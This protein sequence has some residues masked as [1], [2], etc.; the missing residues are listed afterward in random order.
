MA[1][2]AAYQQLTHTFARLHRFGHLGAIAGWDQAAMMPPKGNEARAAAMAELQVL[3]HQIITDPRI[4]EQLQAAEQENL[5]E[6]EC[7]NLREMRREW[8]QANLLPAN[9]VEA[10]ALAGARCEHAWRQQRPAND[11]P[12]FAANLRE[13]VRLS[14]EEGRLL[15]QHTG[16]SVYDALMDKYEPGSSSAEVE[17]I[18]GDIK[19]WLPALI[20]QVR[21]KQ[22]SEKVLQ[23]QGPFPIPQ[24]RALGLAVMQLLQFDFDAGRLDISSHPFCGGVP[25]DVRLTTRYREDDFVQSLMGII[26]ETGHARYEQNLPRE[27]VSQ[28]VGRARSMAIHES[29]SLSFEMQ[30]ARSSG[31]LQLITPLI[32]QHLGSQPAFTADNLAC[33]YTRVEP[34]CIRVDADELCYPAHVILRFEIERALMDGEIEVEDIPQLWDEKMLA[35]L[36][37]DTRGNYRDGCMQDIHWTDGA[38]GYFPSYTLGA[39]YAAQYFA[40]LR[41]QQPEL[42]A[43]VAAGQ[44]TPIFDYLNKSVWSQASRWTRPE[45]IQQATGEMLNPAYFR[46]HLQQRYLAT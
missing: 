27:Y 2:T 16:C 22:S 43:Q 3:M 38:F 10:K 29:Q 11:W 6:L 5:S 8:A 25:E 40:I 26:H 37:V 34:S 21:N 41:Q 24:Q 45:L 12:G 20:E 13:V 44:L 14:R 9:L 1:N 17:Q 15:A 42:N 18:F 39:M 30:L 19:N 4:K 23:P 32:C 46:A 28:P 31:F 33:L 35:Y 7:A 36:G